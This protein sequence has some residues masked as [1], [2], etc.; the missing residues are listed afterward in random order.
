MSSLYNVI[1]I[2]DTQTVLPIICISIGQLIILAGSLIRNIE[3]TLVM[4]NHLILLETKSN[5]L[6]IIR[7]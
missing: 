7:L 6:R 4:S 1:F 5:H 3:H 2:R